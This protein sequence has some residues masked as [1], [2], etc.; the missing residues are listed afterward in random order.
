MEF[1]VF[2]IR[3]QI[4]GTVRKSEVITKN[5]LREAQAKC[6]VNL[7]EDMNDANLSGGIC[8]AISENGDVILKV[9]WGE[10]T[11]AESAE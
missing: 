5:S 9:K 1:Y 6:H 8:M 2:R 10:K 7:G 3:Y 11:S 4:D